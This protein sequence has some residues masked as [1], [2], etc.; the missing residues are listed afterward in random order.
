MIAIKNKQ[1]LTKMSVAGQLLAEVFDDLVEGIIPGTTTFDI[2]MWI[3]QQLRTR[4][5]ISRSLGYHGYKHV[6]CVSVNDEVIHGVPSQ[7]KMLEEGDL[8]TVDVCASWKG[9]CA[10]MARSFFVGSSIDEHRAF[11]RVAQSALDNGIAQAQPGN[12]LSDI[13]AAVQHEVERH[14]YGV[15]RDFAGHGIGKQMHEPPEILNFGK[16]GNGPILRS[17][18]AL[19]IEPMITMGHYD[20]YVS[21][22]GWTVKTVD[23]KLAAHIED[24]VIITDNGPRV[25]TRA[26]VSG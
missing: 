18:M 8:V 5:L 7:E 11:V 3:A 9:Y 1:A 14:G 21:D 12:R 23:K 16:P 24:T 20:V 13:S 4:K 17:G 2:D 15:L 26:K 6:S 25:L 10:D 19:A 22:D